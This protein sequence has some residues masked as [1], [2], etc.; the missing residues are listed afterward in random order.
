MFIEI[1]ISVRA[2]IGKEYRVIIIFEIVGESQSIE[3][4]AATHGILKWWK[5]NI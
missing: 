3:V 2:R 4:P 5:N 1:R